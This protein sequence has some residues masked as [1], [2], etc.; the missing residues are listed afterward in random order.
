MITY[1]QVTVT[2]WHQKSATVNMQCDA[3]NNQ[4]PND[5]VSQ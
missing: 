5:V 2:L 1:Y 4:M 3:E